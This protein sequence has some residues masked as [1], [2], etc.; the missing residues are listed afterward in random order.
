MSELSKKKATY[1]DL[2]SIPENMTGEIINGELIVTPRPSRK[3]IR[4]AIVLAN[5]IGSPYDFGEGG[6][7]GGWIFLIE[8]E[9]GLGEHTMVPGPGGLEEEKDSQ[10]KK[11]ITGFP[12]L[13]IGFVKCFHQI[14]CAPTR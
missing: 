11:I 4:T 9:I 8:P 6:G 10:S 14:P 13:R 7:P 12:P 3:H 2:Y 5:K 1:E